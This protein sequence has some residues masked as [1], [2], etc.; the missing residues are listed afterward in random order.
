MLLRICDWIQEVEIE[1]NLKTVGQGAFQSCKNLEKV[2]FK[3]QAPTTLYEDS[4]PKNVTIYY[5]EGADGWT[6]PTWNGTQ[7]FPTSQPGQRNQMCR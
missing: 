5:P 4:F 1:G 6:T 7:R 2:I 3:W